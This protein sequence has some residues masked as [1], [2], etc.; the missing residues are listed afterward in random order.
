MIIKSYNGNY[1][2]HFTNCFLDSLRS[3]AQEGDV[4]LIDEN[5]LRLYRKQFSHFEKSNTFLSIP[6][7]ESSK[8]FDA[9]RKLIH[10]L[11][12]LSFKRNHRLIAVGG[13][14][15]QDAVAFV[16]SILFRGVEWIFVPTTLLA[17]GDSCIGSKTS[18]NFDN[19]KNL[20]G[21]FYPPSNIYID[22]A[23]LDTLSEH[24]IRSGLGEM[25]HFFMIGGKSDF[26]IFRDTFKH[27]F[28][29]KNSIKK[30]TERSLEIKKEMIER[31]EFDEGPRKVFNYGH[32]FGHA[33]EGITNYGIPHGIA[34]S[35]GMDMANKVSVYLG[36]LDETIAFESRKLL[37]QVW[38]NIYF[39]EIN[40][41]EYM[42]LLSQDK[43]NIG[44]NL[45][46]ILT[47]GLGHMFMKE[48]IPDDGFVSV[49]HECLIFYRFE[50]AS[51]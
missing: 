2:V 4:F 16:A 31:D 18:V 24:E 36:L 35:Y 48:V 15:V 5:V 23:F 30:L 33:L 44:N 41:V 7:G 21:G 42:K 37:S 22:A 40:T 26:E 14:I 8:S 17:Q 50:S 46:L 9:A 19:Y 49:V 38:G 13:G 10:D 39:P 32:T 29:D 20:L 11:M 6:S 27:C 47:K 43:K 34:V 45:N 12:E 3:E 51:S 1:H 25:L 28:D